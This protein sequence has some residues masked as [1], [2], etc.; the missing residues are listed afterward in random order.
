MTIFSILSW[1]A[2]TLSITGIILNAKKIIYCWP[3]WIISDIF[4]IVVET[5]N[6]NLPQIILWF[7]FLFFNLYGLYCWSNERKNNRQYE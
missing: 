1:I 2:L 7:I 5:H 4:W 6:N 3:V